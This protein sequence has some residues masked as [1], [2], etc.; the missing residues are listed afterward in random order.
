MM[1]N[2]EQARVKA[3]AKCLELVNKGIYVGLVKSDDNF[4]VNAYAGVN[5]W[6]FPFADLKDGDLCSVRINDAYA[7]S[8]Y[9]VDGRFF[10]NYHYN[11]KLWSGAVRK[12]AT[13]IKK[14]GF[15]IL[16]HLEGK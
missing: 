4:T 16:E 15:N 14:T 12:D 9:Y 5:E 1:D 11:T 7:D 6:R 8:A 10:F 13:L 3:E 2:K